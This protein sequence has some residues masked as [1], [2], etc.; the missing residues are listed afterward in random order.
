LQ[1]KLL[2][3]L[4]RSFSVVSLVVAWSFTHY[5]PLP[6]PPPLNVTALSVNFFVLG[7][8]QVPHIMTGESFI[9]CM[10]S[11]EVSH[12]LHTYS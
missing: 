11:M 1:V 10:M 3:V 12:V 8:E 9:G 5:E 2:R 4:L 7:F 6:H